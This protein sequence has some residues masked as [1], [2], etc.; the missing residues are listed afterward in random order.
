AVRC[1]DG[2]L[3]RVIWDL[4]ADEPLGLE[5]GKGPVPCYE[6]CSVLQALAR[7]VVG[8]RRGEEVAIDGPLWQHLLPLLAPEP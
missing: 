6:P 7:E 3:R 5:R 1:R 4:A 8:W 2:C